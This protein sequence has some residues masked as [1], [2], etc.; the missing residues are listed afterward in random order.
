[1]EHLEV[2]KKDHLLNFEL[3]DP[4]GKIQ[5]DE[6]FMNKMH[7]CD[8][9]TQNSLTVKKKTRFGKLRFSASH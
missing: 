3:L 9:L 1:M 2:H 7:K 8:H 6:R 4:T 5:S